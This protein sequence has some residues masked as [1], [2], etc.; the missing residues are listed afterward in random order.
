MDQNL[1]VRA[2]TMKLVEENTGVNLCDLRFA[3][4]VLGHKNTRQQKKKDVL[5][6]IKS[7]FNYIRCLYSLAIRK[8]KQDRKHFLLRIVKVKKSDNY[9]VVR[10]CIVV[11]QCIQCVYTQVR[12][13]NSSEK[14]LRNR[15]WSLPP[16]IELGSWNK[17]RFT[18]P[19]SCFQGFGFC[20]QMYALPILEVLKIWSQDQGLQ[21]HLNLFVIPGLSSTSDLLDQ[22]PWGQG[23]PICALASPLGDSDVC[24]TT[25]KRNKKM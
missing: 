8:R 1:N 22:I 4:G 19:H 9:Y 7:G 25:C 15:H 6:F 10:A 11:T 12:L 13:K 3:N 20:F 23:L 17:K 14:Y 21:H 5:D 18:F 24:L 2:K 16:R